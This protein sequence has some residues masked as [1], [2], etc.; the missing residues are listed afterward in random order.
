MGSLPNQE[1]DECKE[2]GSINVEVIYAKPQHQEIIQL[3]LPAGS[4]LHQAIEASG[5]IGKFPE[6]DLAKIKLG[7][8]GKIAMATTVLCA[9]DR[10]EIY[11]PLLADPK[12]IRVR[13]VATGIQLRKRLKP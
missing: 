11:R 13:R 12:E 8:Y 6:I 2:V 4:T 5:L 7:I 1:I 10:V 9:Q 3:E